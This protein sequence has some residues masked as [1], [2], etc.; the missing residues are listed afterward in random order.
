M[1][2]TLSTFDAYLHERIIDRDKIEKLMYPQNPLLQKLEK[3]G[4][5]GMIG[6]QMPVPIMTGLPQGLAGNFTDAQ[7]NNS[8]VKADKFVITAGDYFGT[9]RIGDKVMMASRTNAGAWLENKVTE[10]DG[11][12]EQ[13]G[14]NF[15]IYAWGNGGGALGRIASI[16]GNN[17][18]L[19]TPQDAQNFEIGMTVVASDNDGATST[20]AERDSGDGTTVA[21]VNRATGVIGLTSAA[22]ISGLAVGDYLFRQGDFFGDTGTIVLKGIQAF[23]TATDA[24]GALWG[25]VAA[26]RALDPQRWAG[27]RPLAA[28]LVGKTIEQRLKRLVASMTSQFKA[29]APTEIFLNPLDF[30]D[31]DTLMGAKGRRELDGDDAK[32]GYSSITL[33]TAAGQIPIYTDRHCPLGTAFALKMDD[34]WISSMGELLRVQNGDGLN[35]LRVYNSTDYEFRLIS[36]P[37]LACRAPKNNGRV[38]LT[39]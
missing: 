6:D 31:L 37:L 23:I 33:S 25:V 30:D 26:T 24:P 9:V 4:D 3:R 15:S 36:Y 5:T 12:Y 1:G 35:V 34:W 14:E 38:P 22:A 11:L 18:T 20:D 17:V 32:F 39:G 7:T 28:D 21:S 16:A 2:S 27:C 13:A 10:I 29:K 19:Q 8:N